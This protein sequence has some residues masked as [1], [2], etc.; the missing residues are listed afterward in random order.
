MVMNLRDF[1]LRKGCNSAMVPLR[2]WIGLP[3]ILLI[4]SVFSWNCV[5]NHLDL[6]GAKFYKPG[7]STDTPIATAIQPIYRLRGE[8][9]VTGAKEMFV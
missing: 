3:A 1:I 2:R 4:Y 7:K 6:L 5:C 9:W 8:S